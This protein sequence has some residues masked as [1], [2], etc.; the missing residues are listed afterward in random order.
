MGVGY[1]GNKSKVKTMKSLVNLKLKQLYFYNDLL[2]RI[3]IMCLKLSLSKNN[4]NVTTSD[5]KK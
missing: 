5:R 4:V 3:Y 2:G 1:F